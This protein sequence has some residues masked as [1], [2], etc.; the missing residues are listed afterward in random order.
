[1]NRS[2]A[3][4]ILTEQLARFNSRS[5]SE[6]TQLVGDEHVEAYHVRAASGAAYHIEIQFFWDDQPG[7]TIRVAGSIDDGSFRAFIPV[8][9]SFLRESAGTAL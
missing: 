6:L 1:M 9:D 5:H 2:E 8:T 7:E 4:Q 3:Q